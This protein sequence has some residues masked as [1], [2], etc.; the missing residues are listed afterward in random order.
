MAWTPVVKVWQGGTEEAKALFGKR[1]RTTEALTFSE[2]IAQDR[3]LGIQVSVKKGAIG[4]VGQPF[5]LFV[6]IAF[7]K[8]E[9]MVTTSLAALAR[10]PKNFVSHRATWDTF[11]HHYE[12]EV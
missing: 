1:V 6:I 12:I 10:S 11:Q 7:P 8:D 9:K 5:G 2:F 3:D 4:F